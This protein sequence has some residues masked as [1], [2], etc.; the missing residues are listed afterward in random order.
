MRFESPM[1]PAARCWPLACALAALLAG[2]LAQAEEPPLSEAATASTSMAMADP[3]AIRVLL[4]PELET[5]LVAQMTGR[6]A[7]LDASLGA[8]VRKGHTLLAFDCAEAAARLKMAQAEFDSARETLAVKNNLR[9]LDAAGD[10]EVSLAH[11]D[12]R[13][14][15]AA[16]ALNRAQVAQCTVQ[17]PFSGRLVRLHVKPYQGV[18]VGAPLF[19]LISD[20]PLKLRLN[21]PSRLLRTLQVGA[22]LEVEIDETGRRYPAKVSAING[23]VDAVAQTVELEARLDAEAAE[24][25]PGM[26]GVARFPASPE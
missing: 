4:S 2:G 14:T 15:E 25:L 18:G 1:C 7:K 20:G 21:V 26:S 16:V 9:K 17:A 8:E 23:R 12:S 13:R 19:E 10:L 3:D 5:T 24:L 22:P 6:I 11:A